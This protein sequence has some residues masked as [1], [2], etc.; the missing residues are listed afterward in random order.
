MSIYNQVL[1]NLEELELIKMKEMLP[2]ILDQ[3]NKAK[4]PLSTLEILQ[5]LTSSE[6]VFRDERAKRVNITISSFPF[7]KTLKD[8]DFDY[9]PQINRSY[10]EDLATLRFMKEH[11]NIV[12]M[13]APGVGKSH[14]AIAIGVEAA[15]LRYSTYF[16]NFSTLMAKI[17]KAI[18]EQRIEQIIKH[19]LKYSLLLIDEIGYLPTDRDA[20]YVFFQLIAARYE[21]RSTIFTTNQPFSKWGEGFGDNVIASAIVDRIIH[22]CEIIKITGQS[23]RIKGKIDLT[24]EENL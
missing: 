5:K 12:F 17:K 2:V 14:L 7:V 8:F 4:Q 16:I 13:G 21:K 22:H 24:K 11:N 19:Y 20:S 18:A 1:N 9:Q 6:I 10:I 23:Y 3:N 15:S